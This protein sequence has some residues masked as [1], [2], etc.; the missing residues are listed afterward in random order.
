MLRNSIKN[1]HFLHQEI[2]D[3]GH[4]K[5]KMTLAEEV[6]FLNKGAILRE[7]NNLPD[8]TRLTVDMSKS[9]NI[10][11]DVLEIIDNF[12]KTS[13]SRNIKVNLINRGDIQT[14][15]Y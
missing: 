13:E 12:Q 14:V 7:L 15:D 3:N 2:V 8:E 4:H 1:S 6:S 5:V 9:V 10:D 11:Y